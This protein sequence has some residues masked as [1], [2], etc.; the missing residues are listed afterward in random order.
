MWCRD[1]SAVGI[2]NVIDQRAAFPGP[3]PARPVMPGVL[4]IEAMA[5]TAAVLVVQ[6]LGGEARGQAGLF[7]DHRQRALPPAGGARRHA[8]H[9]CQ[10]AAQRG[11]VWKFQGEAMVDGQAGGR[12]DIRR[13]DH[14]QRTSA[15]MSAHSSD[16]DRRAGRASSATAVRSALIAMSAGDVDARRRRRAASPCRRRRPHHDRRRHAHLSLRLDRPRSRRT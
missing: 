9:P 8:A 16:G 11:N 13:D 14:G 2:K 6:T 7:H 12:G 5:Q 3:F 4:I 15:R 10:Q 1:E